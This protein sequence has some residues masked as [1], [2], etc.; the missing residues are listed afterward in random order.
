MW[1]R[2]TGLGRIEW[3]HSEEK[4]FE[5]I[6]SQSSDGYHQMGLTRM[7]SSHRT[8]VVDRKLQVH[9]LSN[10]Y[11]AAPSILPTGGRAHPTFP[12]VALAVRLADHLASGPR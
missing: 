8:G 1:M 10:L 5:Q 11:I 9:G 6:K 4:R 3:H 7:A 2:K 12:T